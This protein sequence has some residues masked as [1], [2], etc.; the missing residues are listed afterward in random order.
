MVCDGWL[1]FV[2]VFG[3][4][5]GFFRDQPVKRHPGEGFAV[6]MPAPPSK[7]TGG[8]RSAGCVPS[9]AQ[10]G[11][12]VFSYVTVPPPTMSMATPASSAATGGSLAGSSWRAEGAVSQ[13]MRRRK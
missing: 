3:V 7:R 9:D 11:T 6:T 2:I 4:V 10:A 8:Q 1:P 13:A 12:V 5:E